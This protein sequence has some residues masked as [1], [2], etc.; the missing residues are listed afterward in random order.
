DALLL[1]DPDLRALGPQWP[2]MIQH[3]VGQEGG[4]L[5]FV[6]GELY[7]QQLFEAADTKSPGGDWTRILPIVRD[8]GLYRS[9]A[10]VRLSSQSTYNLDLTPEGRGDPIFEFHPDPIRNRTILTSLPGMYWS[11]PVTRARPGATVLA[12]HGDPRMS[13]Q[14]GRHVLLASQLYGPGRTVFLGFD[15][16]YRW[17]YLSEDYFDGFWARLVDR[18]GRN[19]ALG[20]RFPFQVHLGKGVYRVGDRVSVGVRYTDPA[21]LAEAAE[22]TAELEIAGLPPEPIRFEKV[23]DDPGLLTTSFPAQ[24]AGAYSLRIVPAATADLG[25]GVRV[26]TT[27]FRVEPPRR[28]IDE[29]SLNRPLLAELARI[30][31][32]RVFDL[33]DVRRL[34]EAITMR[35]VVRTLETRDELWDAPLLY[36]I[37]VVS[38]TV[39]WVLRKLYRMV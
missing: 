38:L 31:G 28:E 7:S 14:H 22:L 34:D 18:V 27:T 26:S 12:R 33:A 10:E 25:S 23:P 11:F 30:T 2:E 36:S 1:V 5:M 16:T 39:E 29:P 6:A 9:E 24:Q 8:P 17:R 3:F 13:N 21:A 19:K 32:G 15:S 4:G 37:L 20:G 35:E